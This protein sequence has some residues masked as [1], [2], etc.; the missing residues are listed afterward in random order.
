[1]EFDARTVREALPAGA[2]LSGDDGYDDARISFNGMLDRKPAAIV[3]CATTGDVVAAVRSARRLGWPIAV[4]GGGHSVAGHSIPD[5]AMVVSLDQMRAVEVDPERRLARAGG[6][7]Q[8][9]DVDAAAFA[10][11]LAVPGGTFGDTGIGGLTLGG[12]LG[13]LMPVAGLTCDNLVA[14]EV[15]TA[16]GNVVVAGPDGD[17]DLL[18]ALRGGGGNFGIVTN[19]TYRLMPVGPMWGGVVRYPAS[20]AVQV[21]TRINEI[22]AAYPRAMMPTV[23]M[24]KQPE[25]GPIVSFLVGVV[26]GSDPAAIEAEIRRD[27]PILEADLGPR[28]YLDLQALAGILPFG[29]R[30]YWK[31]HFV[32]E[33]SVAMFEALAATIQDDDAIGHSIILLEGLVGEGRVEPDDGA[34]FGQRG[35]SWNASA[36]AIWESPDDDERLVAWARRIADILAPASLTGAGYVNYS[37]VDETRERVKAAYGEDRYARLLSV[38]RRLDPD[39]VFR[40]NHNIRPD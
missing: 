40:F 11:E 33:L 21:I 37:P 15:V 31:G 19:F 32:R 8:W 3:S 4:R 12:G 35:A 24:S 1:M 20:A 27:L 30:H 16:D 9:N 36:L 13:W 22:V 28:T 17:A 5:A 26:D 18:W 25:L 34:A 2:L 38:K 23:S 14:A 39:N 10:H 6:G 7:A 29:L